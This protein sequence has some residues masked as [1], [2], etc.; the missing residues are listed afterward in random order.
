V[1]NF[2]PPFSVFLGAH[3]SLFLLLTASAAGVVDG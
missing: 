2:S 1:I 3:C